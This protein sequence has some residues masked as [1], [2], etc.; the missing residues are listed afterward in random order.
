[1]TASRAL[2]A[3]LGRPWNSRRV[4]LR[5]PRER[6]STYLAT[7]SHVGAQRTDRAW[8]LLARWRPD[9][10]RSTLQGSHPRYR[11][12]GAPFACE[13]VRIATG[14]S[15][16]PIC[17]HH[18]GDRIIGDTFAGGR[19]GALDQLLRVAYSWH[20]DGM[21][22][23]RISTTVDSELLADARRT[24]AG[25][26]DAQLIDD[27]LTALL[28]RYRSAEIDEVYAAAYAAH[29]LDEADEWGDLDSFRHAAA[30][31]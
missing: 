25:S 5:P 9:R 13:C 30:A 4:R 20:D 11:H 22:R 23:V 7:V 31:T 27:A 18:G 3:Q 17:A 6:T 21:A 19:F 16:V 28:A 15:D 1:M 14:R 10:T 26:S 2:A 8:P 12:R 24:H 29:P